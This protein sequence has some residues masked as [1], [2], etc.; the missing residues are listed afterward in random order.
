MP[1]TKFTIP[2]IIYYCVGILFAITAQGAV[3]GLTLDLFSRTVEGQQEEKPKINLNFFAHLDPIALLV[4]FADG[5][6]WAK[7]IKVDDSQLKHPRIAWL[8]TAYMSAL[9]N[10][11]VAVSISTISDIL[12]TS[13]AFYVVMALNASVFVYHLL[14]PIPP[15]AASRIIY[16]LIPPQHRGLWR[17]Y[18]RLGPFILLTIAALER[19]TDLSILHPITQPL[20]GVI[21]RF[22]SSTSF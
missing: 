2:E 18:A 15:L 1:L 12:W 4:F 16:A 19:F 14:V 22:C 11:L 9:T 6:G 17:W 20:F 21:M 3:Q 13:R 8:V 7:V 5:F 10:L